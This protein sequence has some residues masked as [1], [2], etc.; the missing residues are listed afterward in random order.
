MRGSVPC[1]KLLRARGKL[2]TNQNVERGRWPLSKSA[3]FAQTRQASV[4]VAAVAVICQQA[5]F[6]PCSLPCAL[7]T[8]SL[9]DCRCLSSATSTS[10]GGSHGRGKQ[11]ERKMR[12]VR[13]KQASLAGGK[14]LCRPPHNLRSLQNCRNGCSERSAEMP[15]AESVRNRLLRAEQVVA[16]EVWRVHT[17]FRRAET[18]TRRGWD[19]KPGRGAR[20]NEVGEV[21]LGLLCATA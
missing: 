13:V 5:N 6:S 7:T 12:S 16:S 1:W 17:C 3:S 11:R 2:R 8:E 21:G 4:N 9:T 19:A 15:S 10:A 14:C 18:S 20:R